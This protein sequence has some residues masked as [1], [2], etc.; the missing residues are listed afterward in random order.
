V[1]DKVGDQISVSVVGDADA[2]AG[3]RERHIEAALVNPFALIA[4][5]GR[6]CRVDEHEGVVPSRLGL[7][8]LDEDRE[9]VG[10]ARRDH[11]LGAECRELANLVLAAVIL[12]GRQVELEQTAPGIPSRSARSASAAV[13]SGS[14]SFST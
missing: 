3:S 13:A 14:M 10:V 11:D 8:R 7:E 5:D 2:S 12:A 1:G 6:R 9:R 4:V